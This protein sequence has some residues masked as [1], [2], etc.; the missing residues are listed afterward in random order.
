[1]ESDNEVQLLDPDTMAPLDLKK[2]KGFVRK[3][4]QVRLVKT[5][6][7]AYALSDEW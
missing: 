4:D 6:L 5:R 3:G 2:P 7:G 1:M